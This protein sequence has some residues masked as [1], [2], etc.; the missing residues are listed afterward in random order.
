MVTDGLL[1]SRNIQAETT[2]CLETIAKAKPTLAAQLISKFHGGHL[3][4]KGWKGKIT[5]GEGGQRRAIRQGVGDL[6]IPQAPTQCTQS[7]Q[8]GNTGEPWEGKSHLWSSE[9][10]ITVLV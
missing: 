5:G 10:M 1:V 9:L 4:Q 7:F 8:L 3:K 6:S 2:Y